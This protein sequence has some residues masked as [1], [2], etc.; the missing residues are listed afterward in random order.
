MD[1]HEART[2]LQSR[3]PD[4]DHDEPQFAGALRAAEADPALAAQIEN[5]R[6]LDRAI[7]G[8]LRE[9]PPPPFLRERILGGVASR[10]AARRHRRRALLALAACVTLLAVIGGNAL[11]S[12]RARNSFASYRQEMVGRL[13]GRIQLSFT[14]ERPAELQDWLHGTRGVGGFALP[15]GLQ[16]L[17]GLGC[18]TWMWNDQP[19]GLICFSRDGKEVVHLLVISRDAVPRGPSGAAAMF[20]QVNG[21]QTASWTQGDQVFVLAGKMERAEMERLL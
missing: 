4:G 18:R 19:A 2:I 12:A 21:W 11:V 8:R 1:R 9:L 17:K 3:R 10:T 13:D 16:R 20:E 6:A 5:D 15:A 14:S 7:G